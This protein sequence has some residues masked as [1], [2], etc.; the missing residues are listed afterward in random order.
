M[1]L[2]ELINDA[3]VILL[4]S[5][6]KL[7]DS[8]YSENAVNIIREIKQQFESEDVNFED[9]LAENFTVL[10]GAQEKLYEQFSSYEYII[11]DVLE[12]NKDM[13]QSLMLDKIY[14]SLKRI[15][16]LESGSIF[17][18]FE[19]KNTEIADE[20]YVKE[21]TEK[22]ISQFKDIFSQNER[23]INRAIMASA[24]S[25]L[26]VFFG[27]VEEIKDYVINSLKQCADKAEKTAVVEI[28]MQMMDE[29]GYEML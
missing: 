9:E 19:L 20:K 5:P 29:D 11:D 6:Y 25:A 2:G 12:E 8:R 7:N 18:D 21:A 28:I 3:Y 10:E 23:I 16:I 22:L 13:L 1:A 26:P 4:S 15:T 27:N 14:N 24:L 17:A